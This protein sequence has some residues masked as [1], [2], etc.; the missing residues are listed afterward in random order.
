MDGLVIFLQLACIILAVAMVCL[1]V[2]AGLAIRQ[3][4]RH[5]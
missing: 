1:V 3:R 2:A 5:P 4:R